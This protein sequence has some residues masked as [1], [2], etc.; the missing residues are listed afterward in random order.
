[1]TWMCIHGRHH[2]YMCSHCAPWSTPPE[3]LQ[4]SVTSS[5][6]MMDRTVSAE[7]H[8]ELKKLCDVLREE[9]DEA[10]ELA[11]ERGEILV[12]LQERYDVLWRTL[13]DFA[14]DAFLFDLHLDECE[15]ESSC[16]CPWP[17]E[18][19]AALSFSAPSSGSFGNDERLA[20]LAIE[21]IAR[22]IDAIAFLGLPGDRL[23][24]AFK[25]LDHVREKR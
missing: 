1:M 9:R 15:D 2:G 16:D 14:E 22:D 25:L 4:F 7:E 11:I 10:R 6:S 19:R 13:S 12:R 23:R 3:P 5:V 21:S 17:R 8:D 24:R 20:L 18:F